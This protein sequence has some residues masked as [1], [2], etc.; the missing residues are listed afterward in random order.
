MLMFS[1]KEQA[2]KVNCCMLVVLDEKLW[3]NN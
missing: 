3:D 2:A 1:E